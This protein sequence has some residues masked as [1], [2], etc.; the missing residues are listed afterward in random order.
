MHWWRSD[1]Y[2]VAHELT[3]HVITFCQMRERRKCLRAEIKKQKKQKTKPAWCDH[4]LSDLSFSVTATSMKEGLI[5]SYCLV[6]L[7]RKPSIQ[8]HVQRRGNFFF[9]WFFFFFWSSLLH[10]T[11]NLLIRVWMEPASWALQ[12]LFN[13]L[14]IHDS[15]ACCLISLKVVS[16][17][18]FF[19]SK[20]LTSLRY[21][22]YY[23]YDHPWCVFP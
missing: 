17:L 3:A 6:P 1:F 18:L 15:V 16:E 10:L 2:I 20:L 13:G 19:F 12:M 4:T 5:S 7:S 22:Y 23:Y 21:Y 9:F 8:H 14:H 11:Q